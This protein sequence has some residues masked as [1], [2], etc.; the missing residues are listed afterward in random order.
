M[1]F[2]LLFFV[3]SFTSYIIYPV[4][5]PNDPSLFLPNSCCNPSVL[6]LESLCVPPGPS[7]WLLYSCRVLQCFFCTPPVLQCFLVL[8][9]YS[10]MLLPCFIWTPTMF[11]ILVCVPA[12]FFQWSFLFLS[13][14]FLALPVFIMCFICF[15]FLNVSSLCFFYVPSTITLYFCF[16]SVLLLCSFWS[17][18]AFLLCRF[19]FY[20]MLLVCSFWSISAFLLR[21]RA[22]CSFCVVTSVFFKFP[23]C[24]I[25]H[26][27]T[28]SMFF[29]LFFLC[30]FYVILL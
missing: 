6:L 5:R 16:Y 20:F 1:S 3:F 11:H 18:F 8:C 12:V 14:L 30:T 7:K 19:C 23:F 10:F 4:F 28:S 22:L 27:L 29:R 21:N 17:I 24:A 13:C 26:D 15:P 25:F 9:V 2:F